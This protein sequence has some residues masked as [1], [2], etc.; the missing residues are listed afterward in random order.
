MGLEPVAFQI[1]MFTVCFFTGA[2]VIAIYTVYSFIAVK[3]IKSKNLK[4]FLL[5]VSDIIFWL[6]YALFVFMLYYNINNAEFRVFYF[7][8]M[9]FG[10]LTAYNIKIFIYKKRRLL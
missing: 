8:I 3:L 6:F 9:L 2:A 7:I 1:I 5:P 10:L 4:K